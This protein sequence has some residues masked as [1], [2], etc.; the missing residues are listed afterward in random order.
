VRRRSD[1]R[2][3]A[4]V[5][6]VARTSPTSPTWWPPKRWEG[7]RGLLQHLT[8]TQE[9]PTSHQVSAYKAGRCNRDATEMGATDQGARQGRFRFQR[10]SGTYALS[11]SNPTTRHSLVA[12]SVHVDAP[13]FVPT[14]RNIPGST[15]PSGQSS[16][17]C[18]APAPFATAGVMTRAVPSGLRSGCP[19]PT[20]GFATPNPVGVGAIYPEPPT[21]AALDGSPL[22]TGGLAS[23]PRELVA[24]GP[25]SRRF[26]THHRPP[27]TIRR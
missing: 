8:T 17:G 13:R 16:S 14:P 26:L 22:V 4:P 25:L 15:N 10:S 9:A 7:A 5:D 1:H 3:D 11:P 21:P 19:C 2:M 18:S 6:H 20:G 27:S 24:L 12:P 23:G